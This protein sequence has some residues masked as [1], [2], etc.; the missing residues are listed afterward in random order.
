MPKA[1]AKSI[2]QK[3]KKSTTSET[4][5]P[6][7]GSEETPSQSVENVTDDPTSIYLETGIL[8]TS[9]VHEMEALEAS[10]RRLY[11]HMGVRVCVV[12][13]IPTSTAPMQERASGSTAMVTTPAV[14]NTA[15][16]IPAQ[17]VREPFEQRLASLNKKERQTAKTFKQQNIE[18]DYEWPVD[19]E[20]KEDALMRKYRNTAKLH[21][22]RQRQFRNPDDEE[23]GQ[24]RHQAHA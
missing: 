22:A 12:D 6:P 3:R 9:N 13:G 19:D 24:Q 4:P 23:L 15:N 16:N 5:I 18:E 2:G 11:V 20:S 8:D 10:T 17:M 7:V 21:A 1:K 14:E